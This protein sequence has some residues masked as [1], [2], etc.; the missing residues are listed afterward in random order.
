M[1]TQFWNKAVLA[2]LGDGIGEAHVGVGVAALCDLR[3][4]R[5]ASW[6]IGPDQM[7]SCDLSLRLTVP[8]HLENSAQVFGI[9]IELS[10]LQLSTLNSARDAGLD[11]GRCKGE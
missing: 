2:K 6:S 8:S 9:R 10:A 5:K 7:F 11:F 1:Q 3:E 4:G